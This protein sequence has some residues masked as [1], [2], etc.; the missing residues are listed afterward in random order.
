[1]KY[2]KLDCVPYSKIH[3]ALFPSFYPYS[4]KCPHAQATL[5]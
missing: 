2:D 3:K 5:S 4:R 1:M